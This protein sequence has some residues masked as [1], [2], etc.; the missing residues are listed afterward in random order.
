[1]GNALRDGAPCGSS[2]RVP[3]RTERHRNG[4]LLSLRPSAAAAWDSVDAALIEARARVDGGATLDPALPEYVADG[5]SD[6]V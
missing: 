3:A 6:L 5:L 4:P 1:M 2:G